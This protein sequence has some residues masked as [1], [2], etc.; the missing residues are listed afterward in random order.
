MA[1]SD[2]NILIEFGG[3]RTGRTS[4]MI[5]W[6]IESEP[7]SKRVIFCYSAQE[8][9]RLAKLAKEKCGTVEDWQFVAYGNST[10][11]HGKEVSEVGVDNLELCL[12][13]LTGLPVRY[14]TGTLA[15]KDHR[16]PA[17][18]FEIEF[19]TSDYSRLA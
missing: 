3:R 9:M 14:I 1:A 6:L 17:H 10:R 16:N 2:D 11:L 19:A 15:G 8:A 18:G 4:R 7:E 13:Y 12:F 5:D